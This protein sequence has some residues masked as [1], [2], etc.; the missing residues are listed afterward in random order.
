MKLSN[1][2]L[3]IH[4]KIWRFLKGWMAQL[5]ACACVYARVRGCTDMPPPWRRTPV[6]PPVWRGFCTI[7]PL[8]YGSLPHRYRPRR[9][10]LGPCEPVRALTRAGRGIGGER[11][12]WPPVEWDSCDVRSA[13]LRPWRGLIEAEQ[14]T[15]PVLICSHT[16]I[17]QVGRCLA[18]VL[19]GGGR[20]LESPPSGLQGREAHR[21]LVRVPF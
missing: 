3:V 20:R 14:Q 12:C 10:I 21:G 6:V 2:I 13:P 18:G 19:G 5:C 17:L 1:P 4:R 15:A 7:V 11:G 9:V 16:S 8:A